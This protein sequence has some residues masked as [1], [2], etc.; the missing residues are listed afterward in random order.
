MPDHPPTT[1]LPLVIGLTGGIGSGKTAAANCF[2][3]FGVD[4]IDTD[5]ISHEFTRPGGAAIAPISAHFGKQYINADGAL[6]REKMRTLVFRDN[7]SKK[8]LE[9][10]LHP[11]IHHETD[12]R[13]RH[14]TFCYVIIVVPLLFETNHYCRVAARTLVID[15]S[16]E[17]QIARTM[18][19]SNLDEHTVRAI[20]ATQVS[21]QERLSRADDIIVNNRDMDYLRQQAGILHQKYL[22]LSGNMSRD[23]R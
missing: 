14:A 20:M 6:N 9:A 18:S 4:I 8:Q 2:A 13:I 12:W 3:G 23:L 15:C 21:R 7:A 11:L 1:S 19:R 10:I 16:E 17:D 22:G 5:V